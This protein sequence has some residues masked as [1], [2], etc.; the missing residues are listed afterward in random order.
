M[1]GKL[2]TADNARRRVHGQHR[3][4]LPEFLKGHAKFKQR[5]RF[6]PYCNLAHGQ[7]EELDRVEPRGEKFIF[8]RA[9][10]R[11]EF[12]KAASAGDEHGSHALTLA[13][14]IDDR[15][16][17][18]GGQALQLGNALLHI[19]HRRPDVGIRLELDLN[20]RDGIPGHAAHGLH[21]RGAL[22]LLFDGRGDQLFHVF[23]ARRAP[24]NV[25]MNP[26]H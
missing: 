20:V 15:R 14:R 2:A 6:N 25:G 13:Q 10:Q 12:I 21:V 9:G 23:R 16:L 26:R 5:S 24:D 1:A 3:E 8:D 4:P 11:D 7:P 17:D 18:V 19:V 22:E